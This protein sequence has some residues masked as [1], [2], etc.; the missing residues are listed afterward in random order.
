MLILVGK[1]QI[2][3]LNFGA[4]IDRKYGKESGKCQFRRE[5][6][7]LPFLFLAGK[8]KIDIECSN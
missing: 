2:E 1:N 3:N 4:K 8:F 6:S 5:N 7:K